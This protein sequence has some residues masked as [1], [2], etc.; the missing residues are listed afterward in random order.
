MLAD[1]FISLLPFLLSTGGAAFAKAV[2]AAFR[3][4][5]S[6]AVDHVDPCV[7]NE[8]VRALECLLGLPGSSE[9]AG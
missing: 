6:D 7:L 3:R 9:M 1:V 4:P 2:P 5:A 8:S